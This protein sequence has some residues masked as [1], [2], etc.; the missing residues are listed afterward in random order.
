MET[1]DCKK[2]RRHYLQI[3]GPL[4]YLLVLVPTLL[5]SIIIDSLTLYSLLIFFYFI[6][7]FYVG[8]ML[9][10]AYFEFN[11]IMLENDKFILSREKNILNRKSEKCIISIDEISQIRLMRGNEYHIIFNDHSSFELP[12]S[13]LIGPDGFHVYRQI[14][15]TIRKHYMAD[16][17]NNRDNILPVIPNGLAKREYNSILANSIIINDKDALFSKNKIIVAS[18]NNFHEISNNVRWRGI[19]HDL[20]IESKES[21]IAT[22]NSIIF[23]GLIISCIVTI[24]IVIGWV[25]TAIFEGSI[26]NA[27]S[28]VGFRL[29]IS[30]IILS[31]LFIISIPINH[32][33]ENIEVKLG[34]EIN[35]NYLRRV[36]TVT[37][38]DKST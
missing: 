24:P 33:V 36:K 13:Q 19:I 29:M 2:K 3:T 21:N 25:G 31:L 20:P 10:D 28:F 32:L 8:F 4:I 18:M 35:E 26:S 14:F 22:I 9:Y 7:A 6:L 1:V 11:H 17:V 23:F 30:S 27:N 12:H 38:Q 15:D 37:S 16:D 34:N 5:V